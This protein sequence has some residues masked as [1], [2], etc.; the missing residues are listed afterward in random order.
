MEKQEMS[1]TFMKPRYEKPMMAQI[2]THKIRIN[3]STMRKYLT[4][5]SV[6][7]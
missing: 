7:E 1:S 3:K 4:Q 6:Q 2:H 5:T